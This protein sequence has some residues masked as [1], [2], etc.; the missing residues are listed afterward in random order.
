MEQG[1]AYRPSAPAP[2]SAAPPSEYP[3]EAFGTRSSIDL[4]GP[5]GVARFGGMNP[6]GEHVDQRSANGTKDAA[7]DAEVGA[8]LGAREATNK[9]N[10]AAG[11]P[12][13]HV[14]FDE[15]DGASDGEREQGQGDGAGV[16]PR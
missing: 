3:R 4:A 13:P 7:S 6:A 5:N 10:E 2:L 11:V 12:S 14:L 8:G 9:G 15:Q 1:Y 16:T